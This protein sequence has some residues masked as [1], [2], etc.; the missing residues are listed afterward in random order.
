MCPAFAVLPGT[1]STQ[2][3]LPR[4]APNS[5]D[6]TT[7]PPAR[8]VHV[9]GRRCVG[10]PP[11]GAASEARALRGGQPGGPR[12][13]GD[14]PPTPQKRAHTL[15]RRA[16]DRDPHGTA[17]ARFGT[18][19]RRT[20]GDSRPQRDRHHLG[21][22]RP[23]VPRWQ[24][25]SDRNRAAPRVGKESHLLGRWK[26]P[27]LATGT[28][29]LERA[30]HARRD[31]HRQ[32]WLACRTPTRARGAGSSDVALTRR[33]KFALLPRSPYREPLPPRP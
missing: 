8:W 20:P 30:A 17:L 3:R 33:C 21:N 23:T 2:S 19:T 16:G 5:R 9:G 18:P 29:A 12:P 15:K 11:V 1:R 22:G 31:G 7:A 25:R 24:P 10:P 32:L 26:P 27:G 13:H 4:A 6:R 28:G 14:R